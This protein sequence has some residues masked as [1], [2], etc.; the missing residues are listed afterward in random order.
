M[1]AQAPPSRTERLVLRRAARQDVP[2]VVAYYRQNWEH[3]QPWSPTWPDEMFTPDFWRGEVARR[4]ADF[5]DGVAAAMFVFQKGGG[6]RLV[7]QPS[8]APIVPGPAPACAM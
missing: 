5:A 7:G 6:E 3:L 1:D 4:Q 2:A 8:L